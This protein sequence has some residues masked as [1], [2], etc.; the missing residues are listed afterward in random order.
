MWKRLI[1]MSLTFGLAANAP[2]ALAQMHCGVH[3]AITGKLET[4]YAEARIGRGLQ[5]PLSLIEVWRSQETGNWTILTTRPDGTACVVASG[6][7]W[8]DDTQ[9]ERPDE[10]KLSR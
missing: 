7:A 3:G 9:P 5:S 8:V 6:V 10:T 1:A 4:L 2:P